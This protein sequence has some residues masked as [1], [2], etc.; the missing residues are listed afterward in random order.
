M[1]FYSTILLYSLLEFHFFKLPC[2]EYDILD[3]NFPFLNES[4]LGHVLDSEIR[5]ANS[6]VWW[7]KSCR[8]LYF[9]FC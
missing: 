7:V 4:F 8:I 3:F 6:E 9:S 1:P 2:Y 5:E